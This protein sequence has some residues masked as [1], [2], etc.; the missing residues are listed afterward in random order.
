MATKKKPALKLGEL[1]DALWEQREIKRSLNEQLKI[2]E[3]GIEALTSELLERMEGEGLD[4]VKGSKSSITITP[5]IQPQIE[6]WDEF[7]K[8]TWR[9]KNLQ[10]LRRQIN[11]DPFREVC[12]LRGSPPPGTT[13]FVKKTLNMRTISS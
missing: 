1:T 6:D 4:A 5:S 8:W 10:M 13:S 11:P 7:L 3:A 9:T 12:G 2:V